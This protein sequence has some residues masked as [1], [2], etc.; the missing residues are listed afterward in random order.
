[1]LGGPPEP[2]PDEDTGRLAKLCADKAVAFE[3]VVNEGF[4]TIPGAV[5]LI[6]QAVNDGMLQ[7]VASGASRQDI[8]IIL[9]RLE[10]TDRFAAIVSADDVARSKPDP[11]T[12]TLAAGQIGVE[13]SA[14]VAI[15]DT[16]AGIQ[17]ARDAGLHALALTTTDHPTRLHRAHRLVD[18]LEGVTTDQLR[19]WFSDP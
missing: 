11:L 18:T 7:A 4:Q 16:A 15:E 5:E 8:V 12:Y 2:T 13:P 17:S 19:A 6:E 14:C 1:M 3:Q 10:L 9:D